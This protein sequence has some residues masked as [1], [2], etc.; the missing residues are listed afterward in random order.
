MSEAEPRSVSTQAVFAEAPSLLWVIAP[1]AIL[2]SVTALPAILL[3]VTALPAILLSVTALTASLLSFTAP[4]LM[5]FVLTAFLPSFTAANAVPPTAR[6]S[7]STATTI[8]GDGRGTLFPIFDYF[9]V[10]A[11][12][13][14]SASV[15]C[16]TYPGGGMSWG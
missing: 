9:V 12:S 3:S 11:R 6:Q 1:F 5:F 4:Y 16:Q 2:P 13:R 14:E 8:A 7:A 10:E 15:S